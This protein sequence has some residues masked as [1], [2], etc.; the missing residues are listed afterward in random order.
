M[1]YI[2]DLRATING[3]LVTLVHISWVWVLLLF[4]RLSF[5][6]NQTKNLTATEYQGHLTNIIWCYQNYIGC[7]SNRKANSVL[8][9]FQTGKVYEMV[10]HDLTEFTSTMQNDTKQAVEKTKETLKVTFRSVMKL[11]FL[12]L[13]LERSSVCDPDFTLCS[14]QRY[15]TSCKQI[16]CWLSKNIY[17]YFAEFRH[18]WC[19]L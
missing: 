1:S 15:E 7:K 16:I 10:S 11:T 14:I 13:L 2:F 9:I 19:Y 3:L 12:Y 18:G 5:F 8:Y 17:L 6:F 4:T